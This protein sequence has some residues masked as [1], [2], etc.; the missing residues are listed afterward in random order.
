MRIP[1]E[2]K[3]ETGWETKDSFMDR[4]HAQFLYIHIRTDRLRMLLEPNELNVKKH[5]IPSFRS[6]GALCPHFV[7]VVRVSSFLFVETSSFCC[8]FHQLKRFSRRL[9]PCVDALSI[10]LAP[11]PL[12]LHVLASGR[13]QPQNRGSS[14]ND[15]RDRARPNG[16]GTGR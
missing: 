8:F 14:R 7:S 5:N 9:G 4:L 1:A 13:Y 16:P 3:Q 11:A 12:R 10:E 2:P 15:P 6:T